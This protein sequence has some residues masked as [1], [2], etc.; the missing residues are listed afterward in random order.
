MDYADPTSLGT[1]LAD[2]IAKFDQAEDS[3]RK[4]R[5]NAERDVDYYDGKQWT[6]DEAKTLRAR[7]QPVIAHNMIKPRVDFLRGLERSQRSDPVALPRTPAHEE[8]SHAATDALRYVDDATHYDGI[9]SD[10]WADMVKC[11]WGGVEV[12]AEQRGNDPMPEIDI[13]RTPW[14]RMFWDPASSD[15]AFADADYLGIVIWM[16]REQAVRTY[17]NDA[18]SVFDETVASQSVGNT[19]DDKPRAY[20]W[21]DQA[22]KRVRV[23]QMYHVG[24]D[25]AWR[26]CEFTRGGILKAGVSPWMD[27]DGNPTHPYIWRS[28]HVDRDNNRY[29]AIRALIDP[30]DELNKRRSKMLHLVSVRQTYGV[31]GRV[32]GNVNELRKQLARPDGHVEMEDGAEY[33]RDFGIIPTGDM[34]SGQ[35]QLLQQTMEDLSQ[36]GPNAAMMG[37]GASSASGRSVIAQQQG[38]IV[39]ANPILDELRSLDL[40]VFR[41]IWDR[42]RQFWTGEKW[43]RVTDDERNLRWVGLNAPV[44]DELGQVVA[45]QNQIGRLDVDII[46]ADAPDVPAMQGE[47]FGKLVELAQAGIQFPQ[48]VYIKASSLRNKDELLRQLEQQQA[49]Q[50]DPM[51]QEMQLRGAQL[52]LADKEAGAMQKAASA[53]KTNAEASNAEVQQAALI[54]Q[55]S[56]QGVP[57]GPLLQ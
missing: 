2:L 30:Q 13:R 15:Q 56:G 20:R 9:R 19:F 18:S 37:R 6:D 21:V 16:D 51:V 1:Y 27:S 43:V 38:G 42:I 31:K 50:V 44:T 5:E 24:A 17:G 33:G 49:P 34:A 41:A 57:A 4:S 40:F 12:V 29:G 8:E 11:G 39:E 32:G 45:I 35:F 3:S 47:E 10:V 46:I 22:R 36:M 48:Q 53:R 55:I 52:E 26:L 25:G 14:D 23:I 7:G 28:L 54:A